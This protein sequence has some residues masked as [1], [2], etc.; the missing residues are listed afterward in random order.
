MLGSRANEGEVPMRAETIWLM[1]A[2]R[3]RYPDVEAGAMV[4]PYA[5][6]HDAALNPDGPGYDTAIRELLDAHALRSSPEWDRL[7]STAVGM[8]PQYEVTSKGE[9]MI[10]GA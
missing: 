5:A 1:R 9:L 10:S 3:A 8:N 7:T 4:D 6:A 2:I